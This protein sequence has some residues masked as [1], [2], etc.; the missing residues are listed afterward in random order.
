[1][2]IRVISAIALLCLVWG[3]LWGLVKHSLQVFP[4]FL[5][6]STRLILAAL[7][8]IL[9][10]FVLKKSILPMRGEWK[11]LIIL[12]A[13]V[14]LGFYA[15]QTFAMQFVDSGLSAVLVFTMPIFIGVLA[16][17]FLNERLN[18]QKVLGLILGTF[19]LIAI[20]WPQLWHL[21][22]NLSLIGQGFLIGSGFF[23]AMA[24]VYI[25]RNFATYDK[26]KLTIW[27][28]LMGGIA[29]FI[30]ALAFE[31]VD[32]GVWKN[33]LNESLLFYIAVVGT[34]FAFVLWN[35]IVSQ[36][37]TFIASISI[38]CIPVLSLLSGALV[39]HEPLTVN[40]LIGAALICLGIVMSSLKR[41]SKKAHLAYSPKH[42]Q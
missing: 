32:L 40:I 24:T 18:K 11:P 35:W 10:Q 30:G 41:R 34:G 12:S 4:P 39:W 13:L 25:K 6:I 20:L 21:S 8:L 26:I 22:L 28:L 2:N 31:S 36:V 1:M 19:G 9:V 3:S 7:T 16:H 37:D 14:C 42:F 5:F 38:M 17:Y 23:W 29:I 27:Q 15:T 33:P